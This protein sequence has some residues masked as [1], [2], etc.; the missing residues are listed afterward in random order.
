M[1]QAL[2][3]LFVMTQGAYVHLD[4]DTVRVEVEDATRLQIPLHHIGGIVVFGEVRL[5]TSLLHRCAE[6]GRIVVFMGRTGRFK[7]RLV[8]PTSGN[9]LLRRAQHLALADSA[10]T[11]GIAR[12]IVAGKVQNA[13]QVLLRGAREADGDADTERLQE[14]AQTLARLIVQLGGTQTLD[15]ARG[16]EGNAAR[17]YFG[18]LDLIIRPDDRPTFRMNGRTRRPPQDRINAI[19]SFLYALALNDCVGAA[20]AVGLDPQVGFLHGLRPGRPALGLDLLEEIRPVIAD[21]LVLTL[22]NRH[23]VTDRHFES[24]A[25]GAVYLS[26]EGR[27]EVAAAFQ[28]RKQEEITH[29]VLGSS[30]PI[31]LIPHVQARLLARH[32]RKDLEEYVPFLYR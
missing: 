15:E 7:A 12:N 4:H 23:Q 24:H 17:A 16:I 21:R 31:G 30:I 11:L 1:Y 26:E 10:K 27:K 22:V 19:M 32:L 29:P 25:G 14:A 9:V 8:G 3:T 28:R 5:S 20:E 2:N 18:V 13:R 6:D